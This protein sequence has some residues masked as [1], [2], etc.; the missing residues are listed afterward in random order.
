MVGW[1]ESS[2]GVTAAPNPVT[3]GGFVGINK[4]SSSFFD[5]LFSFMAPFFEQH[6]RGYKYERVFDAFVNATGARLHSQT[7]D[8]LPWM[9]INLER[10]FAGACCSKTRL[11]PAPGFEKL[12]IFFATAAKR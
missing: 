9:N 11:R 8:A 6:G 10:E 5:Q 3:S 4:F 2:N 12:A 7:I 1:C